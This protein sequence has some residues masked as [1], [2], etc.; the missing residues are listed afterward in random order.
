M[1][2]ST[3][4]SP[5]E[6]IDLIDSAREKSTIPIESRANWRRLDDSIHCSINKAE[7]HMV[8]KNGKLEVVYA[9]DN[10][11]NIMGYTPQE[12]L[13]KD[14]IKYRANP[15]NEDILKEMIRQLNAG[16]TVVKSNTI[17]NKD[18]TEVK[19]RGIIYKD[20]DK[21]VEVVW[22]VGIEFDLG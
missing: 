3:Q 14:I 2:F 17:V 4:M 21:Y 8:F 6:L 7:V 16:E 12:L 20:L 13:G 15:L 9:S 1:E 18:G 22:R 10:I 11:E 5:K 19:V